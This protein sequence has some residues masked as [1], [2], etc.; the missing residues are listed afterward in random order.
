MLLTKE[1]LPANKNAGFRMDGYY[2]WCGSLIKGPDQKYYLFAARWPEETTFPEGYMTHSEIVLATSTSLNEPFQFEKVV[3][4]RRDGDYWDAGMAHNPFVVQIGDEYVMFYIGTQNG[5]YENRAIGYATASSLDGEWTRSDKPLQ[6]PAN[7]NNPSVLL[8]S[9][10]S[11]LLYYR[12]GQLKVSVARASHYTG[13]YK[14]LK[15][16]LFPKGY[17][18]DIFVFRLNDRYEMF[19]EDAGAAYTGLY[20]GGVHFVSQ[21]GIHWQPDAQPS[22]YDF[23]I[24]YTDG[25]SLTL[26]RRER[27]QVYIEKN[28][29][30][31][32]TTAKAFGPDCLTGGKTWNMIQK[33]N[34]HK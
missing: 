2:I 30:Y 32:V 12:D 23:N 28:D 11:I 17:I 33:F 10:G 13:P 15:Y 19:A 4:S 29:A 18:E 24:Q 34:Q 31:L 6:L 7:A 9:D 14:I 3:I 21:D 20:K 8:D 5:S 27:P 26:Q 1:F 22:A 25:T 16:D